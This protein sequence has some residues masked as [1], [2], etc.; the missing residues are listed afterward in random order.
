MII[1]PPDLEIF[2]VYDSGIP[3]MERIVIRVNRPTNLAEYFLILGVRGP[4][5]MDMIFP[6][7]DQSFWLGAT[8]IDI[9]GWIFIFTGSGKNGFSLEQHTSEPLYTMYWN[10][11]QV[12]LTHADIV[13][14]IIHINHVQIGNYPNKSLN[15][16]TTPKDDPGLSAIQQFLSKINES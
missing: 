16:F 1:A 9:P 10:K 13:P 11:K 12:A 4:L 15:D 3:N 5:G 6:I 2:G 8:T 7:P 14:A